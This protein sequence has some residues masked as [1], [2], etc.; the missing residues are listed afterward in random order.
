LENLALLVA[1]CCAIVDLIFG[2]QAAG[3]P[4]G[5]LEGFPS[6]A[7]FAFAAVA[8]LAAGLDLNFILS[9]RI[10]PAK[11][12]A[13]HVWRMC[14]ALF[15]ASSSFFLGQQKVMPAFVHGSPLLIV[16]A[17]AP[18]LVMA[19]W[20]VRIRFPGLM[21]RVSLKVGKLPDR[22]RDTAEEDHGVTSKPE[23]RP[24][25]GIGDELQ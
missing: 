7:Y 18:L 13:R 4:T 6:P 2:L 5:Q 25:P 15:I 16:V 12:L 3:S 8:A 10:L 9:R 17:V 20:L 22:F 24:G 21:K 14:T 1:A 19:F 23:W 11:R